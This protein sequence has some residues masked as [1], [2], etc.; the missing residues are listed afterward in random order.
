M[1][2]SA[3]ILI[4]VLL[5]FTIVSHIM[6]VD[7]T[8]ITI[9]MRVTVDSNPSAVGFDTGTELITF[10]RI[11]SG[12]M[13]TR[14]IHLENNEKY[15]QKVT[16]SFS[17]DIGTWTDLLAEYYELESGMSMDV[18]VTLTVPPNTSPGNHTGELTLVFKKK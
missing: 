16:Y 8:T 17:G 14:T 3:I 2:K 1:R 12:S 4:A 11:G 15:A 5:G 18:P 10:G 13:S 7:H 9:P 6:L